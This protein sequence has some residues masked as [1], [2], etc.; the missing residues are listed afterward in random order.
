MASAISAKEKAITRLQEGRKK[1]AEYKASASPDEALNLSGSPTLFYTV[2]N[3]D[4][5]Q[6]GGAVYAHSL[7]ELFYQIIDNSDRLG[8]IDALYML[9]PNLTARNLTVRD[10]AMTSFVG[11]EDGSLLSLLCC[12]YTSDKA[13]DLD[14]ELS[15][16]CMS[17]F[18]P[19]T[20]DSPLRIAVNATSKTW[21]AMKSLSL[22]GSKH[23]RLLAELNERVNKR[24][25]V[26]L[27][28][29]PEGCIR[30]SQASLQLLE[31]QRKAKAKQ[32]EDDALAVATAKV[33]IAESN[34]DLAASAGASIAEDAQLGSVSR[35]KPVKRPSAAALA[36]ISGPLL[37]AKN[38]E[39]VLP[40][41]DADAISANESHP[42][43][44]Q[45]LQEDGKQ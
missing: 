23:D 34:E 37:A 45:A 5:V 15:A 14:T 8:T 44:T 28:N 17:E 16:I 11:T 25:V 35:P 22:F 12:P 39:T 4:F 32:E 1:S 33:G 26:G 6:I 43:F 20:S 19:N 41:L 24:Q 29:D 13:F 42:A 36:A 3:A 38:E 18:V 31:E 30:Y 21:S 2:H 27:R 40:E 10:L 9:R 7:E